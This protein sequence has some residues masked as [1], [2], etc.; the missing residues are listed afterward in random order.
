ML[1]ESLPRAMYNSSVI[2]PVSRNLLH[3]SPGLLYGAI[4]CF[5]ALNSP[6]ITGARQQNT[7]TPTAAYTAT[8]SLSPGVS[9]TETASPTLTDLASVTVS[10][11]GTPAITIDYTLTPTASPTTANIATYTPTMPLLLSPTSSATPVPLG[12]ETVSPTPESLVSA[13][14]VTASLIPL[15]AITYQYPQTREPGQL[16]VLK[17]P[18]DLP[19]LAK[20]NGETDWK[21]LLRGWPLLIILGLW[22]VL[23]FW[24]VLS[25]GYLERN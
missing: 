19:E 22:L 7:E 2:L 1:Q 18:T 5:V 8:T 14:P 20:G 15:P 11:T 23:G 6:W 21:K 3:R 9:P 12:T 17:H 4:A 10:P 24:F 13:V 25:Q 16:L